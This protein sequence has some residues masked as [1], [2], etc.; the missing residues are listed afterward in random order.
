MMEP[1][2]K[3]H[4]PIVR[5]KTFPSAEIIRRR[6]SVTIG[7]H[8]LEA[9][10]IPERQPT[11]SR[12]KLPRTSRLLAPILIEFR[13]IFRLLL[14]L[15][16]RPLQLIR[17]FLTSS[18]RLHSETETRPVP[19]FVKPPLEAQFRLC[20]IVR[21]PTMMDS[22]LLMAAV[23][24]NENPVHD[25]SVLVEPPCHLYRFVQLPSR[26][27]RFQTMG[28]FSWNTKPAPDRLILVKT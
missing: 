7:Y 13:W 28:A 2:L 24:W 16:R 21:Q 12:I 27:D 4:H 14:L 6:A 1:S 19:L 3:N 26:S 17:A 11:V 9:R 23:P 22:S 20:R 5:H 8:H 25:L 18:V 15:Y 10:T